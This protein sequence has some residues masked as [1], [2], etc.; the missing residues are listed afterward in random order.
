VV[1]EADQVKSKARV[2]LLILCAALAVALGGCQA[3]GDGSADGGLPYTRPDVGEPVSE[4]ELGEVTELALD[5]LVRERDFLRLVDERAHGWPESAPGGRYA[6]ATWWSGV[7]V[8]KA[9]GRVTYLHSA[10]GADNNALRTA[11]LAEAAC[12]AWRLGGRPEHLALL[13]RL[14]RGFNSWALAMERPGLEGSRELLAR[15]HYGP[16]VTALDGGREITLDTSL[17]LPGED[18]GACQYVHNPDNPSFGD[19]WVKN[20]RSKDDL[21]HLMRAVAQLEACGADAADPALAVD[22][23]LM[24]ELYQGWARRVEQDG[25][26]LATVDQAGALW[27]PPDDLAHFITLENAECVGMLSLRLYA[28]GEPGTLACGDGLSAVDDLFWLKSSNAQMIRAYQEAAVAHAALAGLEDLRREL[29]GGLA[30]RVEKAVGALEDGR[31]EP[32][33]S[34]E[35]VGELLAQ[36]VAVGLPLTSRE[37]RCLHARIREAH[38]SYLEPAYDPAWRVFDPATPDGEYPFEAPGQG[39]AFRN[40]GVLLGACASPW[41][42]PTSRPVLECARVRAAFE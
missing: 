25:W 4:V 2:G 28:H 39:L 26:A 12:F 32:L 16:P 40:L 24:R 18:N 20:K 29:L 13:R 9:G 23:A 22:L 17:N 19:V 15:A 7:R 38:A 37:V 42:N 8:L 31:P 21:G 3:T 6:Y 36:A 5:L 41:A 10:D 11:P 1:E 27:M 33:P 14:V 34:A 30:R 35:D